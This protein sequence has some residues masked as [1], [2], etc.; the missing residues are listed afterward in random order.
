MFNLR[1]GIGLAIH[2]FWSR[3]RGGSWLK[4]EALMK[5][6][7]IIALL[8]GSIAVAQTTPRNLLK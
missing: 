6:P 5:I 4:K 3:I 7:A 8:F 2:T 1:R